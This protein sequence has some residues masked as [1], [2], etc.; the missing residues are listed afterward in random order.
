MSPSS[1]KPLAILV[2]SVLLLALTTVGARG[3][4]PLQEP[5]PPSTNSFLTQ[6]GTSA[7][8]PLS[9]SFTYQG[10]LTDNGSP[11]N[12]EYDFRFILYDAVVGGSQVGP[13]E[14]VGNLNVSEGLFTASL[15]FGAVF[16]G[17]A[18]WLEI[19]VRPGTGGGAY[20]ILSR[21]SL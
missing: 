19:G 9:T 13:V 5:A 2:V 11:A 17:T 12:G 15:D 8:A 1:R 10:E 14:T 7:S 16:T 20:T 18:V 3:N 6:L 4:P 21:A